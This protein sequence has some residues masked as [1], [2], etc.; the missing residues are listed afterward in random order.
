M[1]APRPSVPEHRRHRDGTILY[2]CTS[3]A[4]VAIMPE[5]DEVDVTIDPGDIEMSFMRSGVVGGQNVIKIET[6]VDLVHKSTS[7]CI[8]VY[9]GMGNGHSLRIRNWQ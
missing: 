2:I 8:Q 3:T 1:C 4:T 9:T 5:C 6:A 7:I